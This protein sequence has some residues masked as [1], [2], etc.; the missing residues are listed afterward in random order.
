ML[1]CV[2]I[3]FYYIDLF[4]YFIITITYYIDLCY[5]FLFICVIEEGIGRLDKL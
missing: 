4:N 2:G 1:V 3:P 5:F